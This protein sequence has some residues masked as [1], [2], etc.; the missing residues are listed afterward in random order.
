VLQ[1]LLEMLVD[2]LWAVMRT[3]FLR[4]E[5]STALAV[6]GIFPLGGAAGWFSLLIW[7]ERVLQASRVPGLSLI[8]SPLLVGL[9]MQAWGEYRRRN[10][11]ATTKVATF[12]GGAAFAFGTAL[13]RFICVR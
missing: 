11:H 4:P 3:V 6:V 5:R 2:V 10:G 7:P 13:V 8:L 9:A 12:A 1:M